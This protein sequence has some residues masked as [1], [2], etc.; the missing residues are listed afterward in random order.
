MNSVVQ[1]YNMSHGL[2]SVLQD[3]TPKVILLSQ[4]YHILIG[5]AGTCIYS[6]FSKVKKKRST[7]C[8]SQFIVHSSQCI[9]TVNWTVKVRWC[10]NPGSFFLEPK[11]IQSI[12]L[13][14]IWSFSKASGL[15]WSDM[16]H[17]GPVFGL[18]T[19]GPWGPKPKYN[20][21]INMFM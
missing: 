7:L 11:D 21:S 15:P 14:A 2:G 5:T 9:E 8:S 4:K 18:G 10:A 6:K 1:T 17:K 20:Q 13:G 12:S 3:L 19:S 16:G